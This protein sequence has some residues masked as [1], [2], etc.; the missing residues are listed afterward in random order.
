MIGYEAQEWLKVLQE[1]LTSNDATISS[2][3]INCNLRNLDGKA[4]FTYLE[5]SVKFHAF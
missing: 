1:G 2:E 4:F 5:A 3:R